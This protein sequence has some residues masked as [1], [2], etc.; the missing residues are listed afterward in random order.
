[1]PRRRGWRK[2]RPAILDPRPCRTHERTARDATTPPSLSTSPPLTTT[3]STTTHPSPRCHRATEGKAASRITVGACARAC[4]LS[5][6]PSPPARPTSNPHPGARRVCFGRRRR[7]GGRPPARTQ[8][9]RIPPIPDPPDPPLP[10]QLDPTDQLAG[11]HA[12]RRNVMLAFY[13][14]LHPTLCRFRCVC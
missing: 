11:R 5:V 1:M 3:R 2:S 6:R 4:P 14:T 10:R 7:S 13:P 9:S 8:A 12:P